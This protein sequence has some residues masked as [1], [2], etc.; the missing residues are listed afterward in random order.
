MIDGDNSGLMNPL[1]GNRTELR[2]RLLAAFDFAIAREEVDADRIVILGHCFGGLCALDLARASPQGLRGAIAVHSPLTA[3]DDVGA[4]K[5]SASVLVL[6]GW[7]DPVAPPEAVVSFA[8]EMTTA[9]A[10]WQLHAYGHAM[11]A[12]TFVGADIPALGIKYDARA[13]RR[14]Q[15]AIE[16]FLAETLGQP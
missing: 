12:F 2:R 3:S 8:A 4:V 10:D 6:H 11:H 5:I 1:L 7:A 14:S 13:H 16:H 9:G 15:H